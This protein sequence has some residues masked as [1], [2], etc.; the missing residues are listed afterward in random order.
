MR[1][2]D[3]QKPRERRVTSA[4]PLAHPHILHVAPSSAQPSPNLELHF[5]LMTDEPTSKRRRLDGCAP[6]TSPGGLSPAFNPSTTYEELP[7]VEGYGFDGMDPF[8]SPAT[9]S[10]WPLDEFAHD[11]DYVA[12][13]ETLRSL[14]FTTAQ[15]AAPTRAGSPI[16]SDVPA[17]VFNIKQVLAHGRRVHYL[18]NYLSAV[19]PWV[20]GSIFHELPKS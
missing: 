5:R 3:D 10:T 6:D 2:G 11:P 4:N 16:D 17:G 1:E 18:R 14:L 12:S 9:A 19:A 20:S 8:L 15:S 7:G 13:Q